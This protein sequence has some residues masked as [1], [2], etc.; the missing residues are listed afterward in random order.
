MSLPESARV[1]IV[2]AGPAGLATA[3][4]LATEKVPFVLV[5]AL[6]ENQN[7]SRAAVIHAYTLEQLD[8]YG[9]ADALVN[10]GIH[11]RHVT[12]YDH[13]ERPL[14]NMPLGD[15]LQKHTK[16]PFANLIAQCEV[17]RILCKHLEQLGG[18]I[19][20]N[21]RVTSLREVNDG[22]EVGLESGETVRADYVVGTDGSKS[23]I[24]TAADIPF[25]DPATNRL[26]EASDDDVQ[27][28]LADAFLAEPFPPAVPLD[29]LWGGFSADGFF[30]LIPVKRAGKPHPPGTRPFR[31]AMTVPKGSASAAPDMEQLQILLNT[32]GPGHSTGNTAQIAEVATSSRY[33]VRSGLASQFVKR[34]GAGWVLLAGDAAHIHSPAGGQGMNIGLADGIALG[35]AIAAGTED[36]L[37]EYE[38]KRRAIAGEVIAFVQRLTVGATNSWLQVPLLNSL[39]DWLVWGVT[40]LPGVANQAVWR[41]SGLVYRE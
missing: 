4:V 27:V 29:R 37:K 41:M 39:R 31:V 15:L 10:E 13:N 16:F 38:Q 28:V 36:S 9:L 18:V 33:R 7:G 2:G 14:I 22:L 24:R 19:H 25:L 11:M 20:R 5:D 32:R 12:S 3:I 17:E 34:V 40:K 8:T 6:T 26:S 23:V 1:V 35:R 21:K 30:V